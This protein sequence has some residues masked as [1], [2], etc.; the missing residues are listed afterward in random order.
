MMGQVMK[1]WEGR[2][3]KME[4]EMEVEMEKEGEEEVY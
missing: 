1:E 4:V 3:E 2:G